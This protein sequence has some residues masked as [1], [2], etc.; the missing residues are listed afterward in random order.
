MSG[1]AGFASKDTDEH[2]A[3]KT[4]VERWFLYHEPHMLLRQVEKCQAI[5]FR[6]VLQCG[7]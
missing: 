6:A 7:I 1:G 2:N 4:A 3:A 5:R